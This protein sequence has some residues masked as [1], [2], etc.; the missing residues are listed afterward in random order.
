MNKCKT[1]DR[2]DCPLHSVPGFKKDVG[3]VR[4][5]LIDPKFLAG[6]ASVLSWAIKNKY[7]GDNW[8]KVKHG[9]RRYLGAL[10]R[11]VEAARRGDMIDEETG[12]PTLDAAACCLM[13]IHFFESA[14]IVD[15]PFPCDDLR[16]D[17]CYPQKAD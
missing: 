15:D 9:R 8:K 16:C 1:H 4:Y 6:L 12:L 2:E 5:E 13:F 11:H 7:P 17:Y 3:K 14:G 10:Y